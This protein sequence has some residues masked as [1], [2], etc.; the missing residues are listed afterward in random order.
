MFLKTSFALILLVSFHSRAF[1]RELKIKDGLKQ[2]SLSYGE[3]LVKFNS[4][5]MKLS[6]KKSDCNADILKKLSTQVRLMLTKSVRQPRAGRGLIEVNDD[7]KIF[8]VS[9]K[10]AS[11]KFFRLLPSE[12]KRI[13]IEDGLRCNK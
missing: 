9:S 4:T 7:G 1:A 12:M 10:I 13:K 2:Y 5:T 8:Y 6:L 11:G 3:E